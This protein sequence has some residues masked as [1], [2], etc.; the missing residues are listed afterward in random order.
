[1]SSASKDEELLGLLMVSDSGGP[2]GLRTPAALRD[3]R[4][5]AFLQAEKH[6]VIKTGVG[7][8]IVDV[9][10]Q[11]RTVNSFFKPNIAQL[12]AEGTVVFASIDEQVLVF[13]DEEGLMIPSGHRSD[14]TLITQQGNR[15]LICVR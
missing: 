12:V 6:D 10:F 14:P 7:D 8:L 11:T 1:M 9:F 5:D 2:T 15:H 13:R 4:P 3:S